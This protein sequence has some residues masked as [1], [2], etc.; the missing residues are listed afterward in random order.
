LIESIFN[1]HILPELETA[2]LTNIPEGMQVE[3]DRLEINIGNI[4][5]N[6]LSANL[7]GR[8]AVSLKQAL[9]N[10]I[11]TKNKLLTGSSLGEKLSD[12]FLLQSSEFFI[13]RGYL[14]A[15]LE[16][17]ITVDALFRKELNQ[18]KNEFVALIEKY[19]YNDQALKRVICNIGNET[20]DHILTTL[21]PRNIQWILDFRKILILASNEKNFN[22]FTGDEIL[23]KINFSI[24]KC[25]LKETG[26][27]FDRQNFSSILLK[28]FLQINP[29]INSLRDAIKKYTGATSAIIAINETLESLITEKTTKQ[30][31][32]KS[33]EFNVYSLIEQLNNGELKNKTNNESQLRKNIIEAIRD[34][35]KLRLL[36]KQLNSKAIKF[37]L[38]LFIANNTQVIFELISAFSDQVI[39]KNHG[40]TAEGHQLMVNQLVFSTVLYWEENSIRTLD[41]EE[42]IVF[43]IYSANVNANK[44][45]KSKAFTDFVTTQKNVDFKKILSI[46]N[47]EQKYPEISGIQKLVSNNFQQ[48]K[49]KNTSTGK[50]TGISEEYFWI[51]CR[52]VINYFLDFG[53]L[54]DAYF[55]V[56]LSDIQTIFR[57]LVQ[58]RN[59][60]P[61]IAIRNSEGQ[62]NSLKRLKTLLIN[63]SDD[64]ITGY[65]SSYFPEEYA[66]FSRLLTEV[67]QYVTFNRGSQIHSPKFINNLFITALIKSNGG[68]SSGIFRYT[69]L[70]NLN[71]ELDKKSSTSGELTAILFPGIEASPENE[72]LFIND[73]ETEIKKSIEKNLK[74]LVNRLSPTGQNVLPYSNE[75][76]ELINNFLLHIQARPKIVDETLQEYRA[77]L[78]Q[79]YSFLRYHIPPNQWNPIEELLSSMAG[80]QQEINAIR[81]HSVQVFEKIKQAQ[82]DLNLPFESIEPSGITVLESFLTVGLSDVTFVEK[83][84]FQ[85]TDRL[86]IIFD[87]ESQQTKKYLEQLIHFTPVTLST[88]LDQ[89]FWKSVVLSFG[90]LLFLNR[91]RIET[92]MFATV[93]QNH[94]LQKL[95]AINETDLFYPI[96]DLMLT[97][98]KNELQELA[99]RKFSAKEI[100][101]LKCS[102][103]ESDKHS[104]GLEI[105]HHLA[106]FKFFAQNGFIPWWTNNLSITEIINELS[107]ISQ[108]F[109]KIFEEVLLQAEKEDQLF[110]PLF[111]KLPYFAAQ[112]LNQLLSANPKLHEISNN[113]E[114]KNNLDKITTGNFEPEKRYSSGEEILQHWY[115]QNTE[116]AEQI[117][118]YLLISPYFYFRDMNPARWRQTVHEFATKYYGPEKLDASNQFHRE[119]L[120]YIQNKYSGID[121]TEILSVVYHRNT[122]AF[123]KEMAKL[124]QTDQVQQL[125]S[126]TPENNTNK[127]Q[128]IDY[129]GIEIKIFN[130]GLVL[131]WPFLTRLFEHLSLVKNGLF[132]S[133]E[134]KN[135]AVYILQYLACSDIDFPEYKLVLNKLLAGMQPEDHLDPFITLS[136]EEIE[137]ANSLLNG[138]KN[139]WEKVKN[140]SIEGIQQTFLQREGKLRFQTEKV[141]LVVEKKGVDILIESIPWNISL[142]KL[143]WMKMPIYVEWL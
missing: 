93:F 84:T 141:T 23:R 115:Q 62:E 70:E 114:Q 127:N 41:N 113:F 102:K 72:A 135:R 36:L 16:E 124:I 83:L 92:S 47:E 110:K 88:R 133:P 7:A 30:T 108:L 80:F 94:L 60:F 24:L 3:L 56:S 75:L 4:N 140:S 10:E 100:K 63:T 6:E 116:I 126:T 131:F 118:G 104:S 130:S 64:E 106:V 1:T 125:Q 37:I 2:I 27:S 73:L 15:G 19:R 98:D 35:I 18:H 21:S 9:Q 132:I 89:K 11:N 87:L 43:L 77:N 68:K 33:Q 117:N 44:I 45:A 142:I 67:K 59:D 13:Q 8:I 32:V 58:Q 61:A 69:L 143:A 29:E 138:L 120:L 122:S 81:R 79:L 95:K 86:F 22:Q 121:W 103:E 76:Q 42:Y 39:H 105:R 34:Q 90:I 111:Q 85:E 31:E 40:K 51:Y 71:N 12:S 101:Q 26:S 123:P 97:S 109:P 65:F 137:S 20:F 17:N 112:A 134:C 91:K 28:E 54:P 48:D 119:F 136:E 5:E 139:N 78:Y 99:R 14:L 129:E 107:R 38:E 52:K 46:I 50:E 53:Y 128:T 49:S 57:D 25:L 96:L 55:D 66:L 74:L 82:T